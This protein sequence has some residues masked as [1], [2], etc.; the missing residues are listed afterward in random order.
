MTLRRVAA[1]RARKAL[2]AAVVIVCLGAA[3]GCTTARNTLGP[4]ESPCFRAIPIARAAVNDKG[5]FAGVRYLTGREF[6]IAVRQARALAGASID[7][8]HALIAAHGPVCAVAYRGS[9]DSR[10]VAAGWSPTGR[11][12]EL[13]IVVVRLTKRLGVLAT[14][15]LH[16]PPLRFSRF[17]PPLI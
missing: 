1:A 3:A 8:P 12:G 7:I 14:V 11:Q 9:Y 15:V 16:K 2:L 4:S 5:R 13:A 10:R 17:F 6:A